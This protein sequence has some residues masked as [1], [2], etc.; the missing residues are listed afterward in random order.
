MALIAVA[1]ALA[2]STRTLAARFNCSSI[3][4]IM[5]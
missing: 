5:V 1:I 3:V 2:W 4:R